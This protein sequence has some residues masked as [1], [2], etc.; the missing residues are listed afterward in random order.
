M[1]YIRP[2]NWENRPVLSTKVTADRLNTM[3]D[4]LA[5][6]A[7]EEAAAR[8]ATKV[9]KNA[10]G[11]SNGVASLGADGRIPLAQVPPIGIQG[12][13]GDGAQLAS[14]GLDVNGI[15]VVEVTTKFGIDANGN[16]YY[17]SEGVLIEDEQAYLDVDANGKF[18]LTQV[19]YD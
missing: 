14:K 10:I 3:Q 17:D 12:P 13:Q 15:P 18:T 2:I 6:Y 8:A 1:T 7:A 9:D 5:Q 11:Q 16:P 4:K 19:N